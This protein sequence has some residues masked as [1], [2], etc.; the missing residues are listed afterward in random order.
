MS[1]SY[2]ECY[3]FGYNPLEDPPKFYMRRSHLLE[4]YASACNSSDPIMWRVPAPPGT[5][6]TAMSQDCSVS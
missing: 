1:Y 2:D 3:K 4:N 6:T 5:A